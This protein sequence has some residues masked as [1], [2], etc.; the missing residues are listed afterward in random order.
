MKKLNYKKAEK[1]LLKLVPYVKDLEKEM[2]HRD[3]KLTVD[4]FESLDRLFKYHIKK[5]ATKR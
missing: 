4:T 3:F 5:R 2:W 1:Y